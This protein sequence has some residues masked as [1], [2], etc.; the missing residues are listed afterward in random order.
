MIVRVVP[1]LIA[2]NQTNRRFGHAVFFGKSVV[3][4]VRNHF[5]NL[6]N[7]FPR[8]ANRA[9]LRLLFFG[10]PAAVIGVISLVVFNPVESQ[11]VAIAGSNRPIAKCFKS[12]P[13]LANMDAQRAVPLE[14]QI[15]RIAAPLVHALPYLIQSASRQ[16]VRDSVGSGVTPLTKRCLVCFVEASGDGFFAT[17]AQNSVCGFHADSIDDDWGIGQWGAG[18]ANTDDDEA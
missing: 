15:F 14:S 17:N 5:S 12:F 3:S 18:F 11:A 13:I 4:F 8:K 6:A 16:T 10:R 7:P 9:V 2:P 1:N